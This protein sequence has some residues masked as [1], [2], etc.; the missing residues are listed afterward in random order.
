MTFT[1]EIYK[2][3]SHVKYKVPESSSEMGNFKDLGKNCYI[4]YYT[5]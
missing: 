5:N 1:K 3:N 4:M 2:E